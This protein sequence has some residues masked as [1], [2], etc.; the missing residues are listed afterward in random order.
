MS[1]VPIH[2]PA[3]ARA[4]LHR[5]LSL[6]IDRLIVMLDDLD[7]DPDLEPDGSDEPSLGFSETRA[8]DNQDTV[9]RMSPIGGPEW[10][11]L[12]EACEDEGHDSD[13]EPVEEDRN[14]PE[15]GEGPQ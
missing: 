13:T 8:F 11:D 1:A 12:E 10:S 3:I 6:L 5:R 4:R 15:T 14:A 2:H 9:I 7:G